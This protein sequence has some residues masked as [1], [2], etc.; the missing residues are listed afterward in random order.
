MNQTNFVWTTVIVSPTTSS[1][2]PSLRRKR[3]IK[4]QRERD[5]ALLPYQ[6]HSS[7]SEPS[8]SSSPFYTEPNRKE[9]LRNLDLTYLTTL[10]ANICNMSLCLP[11]SVWGAIRVK[12]AWCHLRVFEFAMGLGNDDQD[13][14]AKKS[15]GS[16]PCSICLEAVTDNG[17]RSWA[18]LQCG[19]QFHLGMCYVDWAFFFFSIVFCLRLLKLL[20]WSLD[21]RD[22]SFFFFCRM[23]GLG[24]INFWWWCV[25]NCDNAATGL[26]WFCVFDDLGDVIMAFEGWWCFFLC[27]C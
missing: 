22:L 3:K 15:F 25:R 11:I 17:D 20:D 10:L 24:M 6:S 9:R 16:V 14:D 7:N 12:V 5:F 4:K 19:H 8:S 13:G 27:G 26:T 23:R 2:G 18:K 1:N 21:N